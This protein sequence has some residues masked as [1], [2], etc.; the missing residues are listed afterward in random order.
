LLL[1]LEEGNRFSIDLDIICKTDR[2]KLKEILNK[3]VES[4]RFTTYE[5]D[6]HRSYLPGV[7]K[8]HYAFSFNSAINDQYSGQILLDVLTQDSVYPE[9]IE[10]PRS[11]I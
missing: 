1:L 8:A 2:K 7:P 5:L 10:K 6:L 11:F 3:V 9:L 4:S